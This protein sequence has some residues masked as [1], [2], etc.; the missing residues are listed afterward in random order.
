MLNKPLVVLLLCI[1]PSLH[2]Q[3]VALTLE[4]IYDSPKYAQQKIGEI[5]WLAD[6]SGFTYSKQTNDSGQQP[7]A[8]YRII[9]HDIKTGKE[10]ILLAESDFSYNDSKPGLSGYQW[11]KNYDTLLLSGKRNKIWRH[12]WQGAHFLFDRK[13]QKVT[14][15]ANGATNLRNVKMSGDG[16][17]IV[18]VREFNIYVYD[19]ATG[20]EKAL[21]SN[22]NANILNGEFDWVYEEEFGSATALKISPDSKKIAFWQFD[23]SRIKEF[24]L[25]DQTPL[26]NHSFKLKYPKAGVQNAVVK[27]GVVEIDGG[28]VTWMDLGT[29]DDIYIPK[30]FWTGEEQLAML[31][32]NRLQNH[33]ELLKADT[34]TGKTSVLIE[35]KNKTW[36]DVYNDILFLGKRRQIIWPSERDGYRHAY[37]YDYS[38]K[39]IRQ[40]TS[41]DWEVSSLSTVDRKNDFL[42]FNGKKD[43]PLEQNAYRIKLDGGGL[44]RLSRESGWHSGSFSPG[45]QFFIGRFSNS[46]TPTQIYIQDREGNHIRFLDNNEDSAFENLNFAEAEF[47]QIETSDGV[48]L[49]CSMIKPPDFSPDQKYPVLVYGYGGPGSQTVLNRWGGSR[50]LWHR[51][52]AAKGYII[53][54]LDNRGTG[55]RGKKFKDLAYGDISKW[56]VFDQI[57]GAKYLQTRPFVDG[58]RLAFWGWSG[59][60]YLTFMM[61]MRSDGHFKTGV[62][63]APVS[64]LRFYDTI[65]TERYMG[66]PQQNQAGY[67]AAN[68]LSYTS[69][70]KGNLLIIHGSGD[71]NV[72]IQNSMQVV[73]SLQNQAIDFNMMIY[74][75]KDHRIHGG[76]TQLHLFRH[77]EKYL[78]DRL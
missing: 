77:F 4:D 39:L 7:I 25:L 72:H 55:G 43:S 66:L 18:Y 61:M 76:K 14:P 42:Y 47:L 26:Y 24:N 69:G 27:I 74:P 17:K 75:N 34:K 53:F 67:D 21:V 38:G 68:V 59:G 49:N 29:E 73:L 31:R 13:T 48:T 35:D 41:G 19:V 50:T 60:G 44:T 70:L 8:D 23:Q 78:T 9:F 5:K 3:S 71:D 22:G 51:Y 1:A 45:F 36:V 52:L 56:A 64:D 65:W 10:E 40:I 30:I 46:S 6:E 32:L 63:V 15:L 2:A 16:T 57:E 11:G 12:S 62:S 58:D 20:E 28:D 33:I 37:L 54:S